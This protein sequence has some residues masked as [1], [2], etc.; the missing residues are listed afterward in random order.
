MHGHQQSVSPPALEGS[1]RA[2]ATHV[3]CPFVSR[4]RAGYTLSPL[5]EVLLY[6]SLF[7]GF[8]QARALKGAGLAGPP[9]ASWLA[10]D[11]PPRLAPA[12]LASHQA[13][14]NGA[15]QAFDQWVLACSPGNANGWQCMAFSNNCASQSFLLSESACCVLEWFPGHVGGQT[16]A[17]HP[18]CPSPSA[19]SSSHLLTRPPKHPASVADGECASCYTAGPACSG[20]SNGGQSFA[21]CNA[22][23]CFCNSPWQG[24]TCETANVG[25][26]TASGTRCAVDAASTCCAPGFNAVGTKP[27]GSVE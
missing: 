16:Q 1:E 5:S 18:R 4:G 8:T 22:T 24:T 3:L 2:T 6:T 20:L 7:P 9:V 23:T 10:A 14:L 26:C 21:G 19:P 27:S 25:T 13:Q 17:Q 11:M 15:S 12:P